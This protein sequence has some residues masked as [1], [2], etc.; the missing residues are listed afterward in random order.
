MDISTTRTLNNGIEMPMFGLGTYKS[1]DGTEV[2][3]AVK[4]ALDAG[5]RA[6]DT[7]AMY[8][9]ETGIGAA[10]A[11]SDVSREDIF[12]TS[13]VWNTDQGYDGTR[14]SLHATLDRLG[15][16][17]LDLFLIH[18][19]SRMHMADTWRAMEELLAEGKVRALGVSNFLTHHLDE[20]ISFANVAPAVNQIEHHPYLQQP[21][22][23]A[24]S[25]SH[26]I[27]V[28]AWAP[29]L[30]GQITEI[31]VIASI[32][33]EL[34]ATPAQVTLRWMLDRNVIVIP[35]SVRQARII[36]NAD[37]FGFSLTPAHIE[38]LNALDRNERTG[39]NPDEFPGT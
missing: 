34:G 7:A 10:V 37:L 13:K 20:L 8:Q 14:A 30:R 19:P 5:Y 6:I 15:T 22:L 28:T 25:D 3:D 12:I 18:W 32:A 27:A 39:P 21:D 26:D 31:P 23:V 9:N 35:K 33:A 16:D 17:Y 29:L 11:R 2:T 24:A 4:W 38:Q 1:G 36:E